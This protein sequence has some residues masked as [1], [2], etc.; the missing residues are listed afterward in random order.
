MRVFFLS[1][2]HIRA[3]GDAPSIRLEKFLQSKPAS[4]DLL[5]LGGDIFDLF[6]GNKK[7]FR[8]K[9]RV[10]LSALQD[11]A[12][13]GVKVH[14]LEGNHDFHV[15]RVIGASGA[16]VHA[17]DFS[18]G[19]IFVSHGDMIDPED[20]GYRF[21]RRATR[22]PVFRAFLWCLPGAWIDA[23][24]GASSK[25]S[26]QYNHE[27]AAGEPGR[28]R[29]RALY[30]NFAKEKVRAGFRH[31]LVGHSHLRDQITIQEG[32]KAGE[33]INLG[34]SSHSLPFAVLEPNQNQFIFR[35]IR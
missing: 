31:V 33:Y 21:L 19:E 3:A 35:E 6:I 14:Y 17:E 23:I 30:L 24:G 32:E 15:G 29:L 13:R 34:F 20:K 18:V 27:D 5:I 10:V 4:G 2:I 28:A 9:H 16:V 8:E 25:K 26:R 7:Y 1:D 12:R 22:H 11:T